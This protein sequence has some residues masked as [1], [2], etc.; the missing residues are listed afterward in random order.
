M[1]ALA[2][3]YTA[4]SLPPKQARRLDTS[5]KRSEAVQVAG[6]A[7]GV[8]QCGQRSAG[9]APEQVQAIRVLFG[10]V[11]VDVLCF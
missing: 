10:F 2:G 6:P 1:P 7:F 3:C 9:F 5:V 8:G 11:V 4:A